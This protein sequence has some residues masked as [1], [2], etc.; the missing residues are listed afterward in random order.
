[1]ETT[2]REQVHAGLAKKYGVNVLRAFLHATHACEFKPFSFS[3]WRAI[4]DDRIYAILTDV[5]AESTTELG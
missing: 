5:F 2:S 1:M 4:T 3:C